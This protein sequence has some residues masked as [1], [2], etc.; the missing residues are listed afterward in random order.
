M[1][2]GEAFGE[3]ALIKDSPRTATILAAGNLILWGLDRVTF[4][5]TLQALNLMNY[6][7][8]K[9]FINSVPIFSILTDIQRENVV[10]SLV[11]GIY[12]PGSVIVNEGDVGDLFYIIKEG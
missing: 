10:S 4:Q 12:S 6:E 5:T 8:N 1:E 11:L 2:T 3:L 9:S 7:E